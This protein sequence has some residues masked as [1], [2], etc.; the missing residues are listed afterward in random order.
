MADKP[1]GREVEEQPPVAEANTRSRDDADIAGATVEERV[2]FIDL[3]DLDLPWQIRT[4][5]DRSTVVSHTPR[6]PCGHR[7][8]W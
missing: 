3:A 2:I 7:C 6:S 5:D 8:R 4:L 1:S